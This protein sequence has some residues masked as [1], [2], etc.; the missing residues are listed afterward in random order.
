VLPLTVVTTFAGP[1]VFTKAVKLI[2]QK[3]S[4]VETDPI[5]KN[6]LPKA[7]FLPAR[8]LSLILLA[9]SENFSAHA[10]GKTVLPLPLKRESLC[11]RVKLS[12]AFGLVVFKLPNVL[13]FVSIDQFSMAVQT[14]LLPFSLVNRAV[15]PSHHTHSVSLA[16]FDLS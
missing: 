2:F 4:T 1:K 10:V 15:F 7:I 8:P 16:L 11:H 13:V 9:V 6:E 3:F 5:F 14:V 12:F